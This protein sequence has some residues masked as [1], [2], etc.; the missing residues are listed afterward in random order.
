MLPENPTRDQIAAALDYE[1][2]ALDTLLPTITDEQWHG[3]MREDGWTIHDIVGHIADSSYGLA[4]L[5]RNGPPA[6][7][8]PSVDERNEQ[9]RQR[10]R[11]MPRAVLEQRVGSGFAAAREA[12]AASADLSV[13]GPFG[14]RMTVGQVL[15]LIGQHAAGHRHEIEA[16]LT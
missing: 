7:G 16:L 8:Q 14:P 4:Y 2:A 15:A 13:P 11:E 10:M 6:D 5:V 3:R 1:Q 9:R 12:L